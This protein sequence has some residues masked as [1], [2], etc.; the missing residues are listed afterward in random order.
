MVYVDPPS[1]RFV[2]RDRAGVTVSWLVA[3]TDEELHTFALGLGLVK[4]WCLTDRFTRYDVSVTRRTAA[5]AAGAVELTAEEFS[6]WVS[7]RRKATA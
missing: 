6:A 1:P 5:V 2:S 3:D 7:K 4:K